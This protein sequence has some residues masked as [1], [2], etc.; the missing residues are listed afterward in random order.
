M[1]KLFLL[2]CLLSGLN[3]Q[4][5]MGQSSAPDS[6]FLWGNQAYSAGNYDEA[7][8]RYLSL[9]NE[10]YESSSLYLNLGNTWFRLQ[11]YGLARWAYEKAAVTDPLSSDIQQN[12]D[13]VRL[14]QSDKITILPQVTLR[15]QALSA[16]SFF[17]YYPITF[18]VVL[19]S[20]LAL[21]LFFFRF[22][23]RWTGWKQVSVQLLIWV[24][25]FLQVAA[26]G[27]LYL[28]KLEVHG[29]VASALS[30]IKSEPNS[31]SA[32]LF[33]LHQITRVFLV[34][35]FDDWVQIRL[36]NGNTGWIPAKDVAFL[37]D[38]LPPQVAINE[39]SE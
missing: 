27:F 33:Q 19:L 18:S 21:T 3:H 32:T 2:I 39:G 11:Q 14:M 13:L 15:D 36:E 4:T 35:R 17:R 30:D 28:D 1:Q 16:M 24:T 8:N 31:R 38:T 34:S 37:T 29:F 5:A 7:V 25:I 10:G 23:R 22:Y 12:L 9:L 6:M 26:T 20:I